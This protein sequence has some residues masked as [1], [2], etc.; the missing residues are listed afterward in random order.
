V[1]T[2]PEMLQGFARDRIRSD[3]EPPRRVVVAVEGARIRVTLERTRTTLVSGPLGASAT[4]SGVQ[5]GTVVTPSLQGGW[6]DIRYVGEG[7]EMH[8]LFSTEPDGAR[9]HLDYT[10][11][12]GRL[13]SPVRY[14]LDYVHPQ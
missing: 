7:S 2:L 11:T 12:G 6:L 1:A 3:M 13:P 5:D 4:T 14:R 8:Q 9:M 10:I